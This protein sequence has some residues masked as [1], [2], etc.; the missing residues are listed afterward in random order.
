MTEADSLFCQIQKFNQNVSEILPD[1]IWSSHIFSVFS[2]STHKIRQSICFFLCHWASP[3]LLWWPQ[4]T[5]QAFKLLSDKLKSLFQMRGNNGLKMH[6]QF[7][8]YIQSL[9]ASIFSLSVSSFSWYL[10]L[11][12]SS[13]SYPLRSWWAPEG[14]AAWSMQTPA[15]RCPL[16]AAPL[17]P[18]SRSALLHPRPTRCHHTPTRTRSP[19]RPP[20]PLDHR[21]DQDQ[22]RHCHL[23]LHSSSLAPTPELRRPTHTARAPPGTRLLLAR[24]LNPVWV[25]LRFKKN[26]AS[27]LWG[28]RSH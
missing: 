20:H 1:H 17:S 21:Q 28:A 8:Q 23:V 7:S 4:L 14:A 15:P 27:G 22:D 9:S 24:S 12:P 18:R 6:S 13:V 2:S 19:S 16:S 26:L 11:S 10:S 25:R 5:S 3:A